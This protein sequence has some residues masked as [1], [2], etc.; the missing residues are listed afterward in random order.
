MK[1]QTDIL[2]EEIE[3]QNIKY[4]NTHPPLKYCSS[5]GEQLVYGCYSGKITSASEEAKLKMTFN[6]FNG[7]LVANISLVADESILSV[8]TII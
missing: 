8:P 6:L 1:L 7:T 2:H 4:N 5:C 3:L